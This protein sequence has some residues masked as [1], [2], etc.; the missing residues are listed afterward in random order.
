MEKEKY[1]NEIF[2]LSILSVFTPIVFSVL[3]LIFSIRF[4]KIFEGR[5]PS[6]FY[7]SL[8]ISII[9]G[10]FWILILLNGFD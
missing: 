10:F 3:C 1:L 4:S 8:I 7:F 6:K 9:T 5:K 2:W